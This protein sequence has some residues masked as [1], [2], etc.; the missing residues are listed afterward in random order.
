MEGAVPISQ[1]GEIL[2]TITEDTASVM[3]GIWRGQYD[4]TKN[5]HT[6]LISLRSDYKAAISKSND[7]LDMIASNTGRTADNTD[8]IG[9]TLKSIDNRLKTLETNSNKK[10]TK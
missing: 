4:V 6:E 3:M 5:I 10:Y 8:G 7:I 1:A 9:T 2:V